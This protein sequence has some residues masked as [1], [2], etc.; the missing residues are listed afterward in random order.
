MQY[1]T[2]GA[3]GIVVSRLC[4]GTMLFG[5]SHARD[6]DADTSQRM[7]DRFLDAGGT[8][9]DTANVYAGGRSE[10][11]LGTA[12]AARRDRVVIATKAGAQLGGEP[13]HPH[14]GLTRTAVLAAIEASLRRLQTDYIDLWYVHGPDRLTPIEET[15]AAVEMALQAGKVRAVGFSNL[16]AWQAAE[17]VAAAPFPLVA[18]QY[19]YSLVARDIEADFVDG[20]RRHSIAL[21]PW[22][23][24]GQGFLSGKYR[25][26]D[27]PTDGRLGLAE[28]SHEEH[29]SRRDTER[30]WGILAAVEAV[31]ER[32]GATPSQVAL[33]WALA[34]PT[35]GAAIIGVRRPEQLE[36]N[37]AAAALVLAADDLAQLDAASSLPPTY[38]H[39]M[40]SVYFDRRVA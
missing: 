5:G 2:L 37:L 10:E 33:A 8:Y 14:A 28:T 38:P 17:A 31:A 7:I 6:A 34:Q 30:N 29:W 39:R 15:W 16:P 21:H 26:G 1:V 22:G 23:A 27:P 19:Q 4:L 9:F 3:S 25:S 12:L 20:F 11:V 18:A 32:H 24:L 13:R 36:D 40:L 35:V